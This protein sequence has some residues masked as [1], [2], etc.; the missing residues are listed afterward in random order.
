MEYSNIRDMLVRIDIISNRICLAIVMS[1]ILIG[2]SLIVNQAE[3][4]FLRHF[5]LV[6]VGFVLAVLIGLAYSIIRSGRY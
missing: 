4:Y 3:T 5:P 6:E 2:C 1:S